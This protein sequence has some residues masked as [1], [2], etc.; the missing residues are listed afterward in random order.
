MNTQIEVTEGATLEFTD[1]QWQTQGTLPKTG[2]GSMS[3]INVVWRLSDDTSYSSNTEIETKTLLL[4]NNLLTLG[5]AGSDIS[6]KDNMTFENS[7]EQINTGLA[8]LSLEGG[9]ILKEGKI[10]STGGIVYLEKGGKQSG[11]ILD[12]SDSTLKLG[13]SFT[14]TAGTLTTTDDGTILELM[15][16]LTVSSDSSLNFY[17]VALNNNTLTLGSESTDLQ[18]SSALTLDNS[19]EL[20]ITGEADLSLLALL[21]ISDGGVTSTGGIVSLSGGGQI[22]GT[23]ILDVSGST[24]V[25]S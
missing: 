12:I 11:G 19:N 5:T 24:W 7:S 20:I 10:T 22:S 14:K 13:E 9:L 6:V 16:N 3:L 2:G 1:N 21:K 25:L 17:Q 23:G 8:D 18:V 15:K 4:N